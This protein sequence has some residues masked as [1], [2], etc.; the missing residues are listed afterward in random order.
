MRLFSLPSRC[1][2]RR[3]LSTAL[4]LFDGTPCSPRNTLDDNSSSAYPSSI[5]SLMKATS[6]LESDFLCLL[7]LCHPR[8]TAVYHANH[9]STS[10]IVLDRRRR[11]T[12]TIS[13]SSLTRLA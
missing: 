10:G 11:F 9:V 1:I 2:C 4:D 8:G 3:T 6:C 13:S 7:V 12:G 5:K